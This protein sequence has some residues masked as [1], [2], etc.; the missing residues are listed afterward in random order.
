MDWCLCT[1]GQ[2]NDTITEWVQHHG[3]Q[4]APSGP[5]TNI[6]IPEGYPLEDCFETTEPFAFVDGFSPNLNKHLHLGHASNFVLAKA[7]QKLGIGQQFIANLG[8]T[9][10]GEVDKKTALQT[11]LNH[12][13]TFNYQID[14]IFYASELHI[15]DSSLLKDGT[16]DYKG[17]KVFEIEGNNVVGLK[18]TGETTY[19]YQDVALAETL[20]APTLY[21]TGFEQAQHFKLLHTLF[22]TVHHLPLG[23]VMLNGKKMSSRE[24]NVLFFDE[25]LDLLKEKLGDNLPLVWNVLAGYILK[26]A[27][28]TIK[29]I[30]LDQIDNVKQSSGLYLSYTL[31]KLK[32]AGLTIDS[33]DS[34]NSTELQFKALKAKETLQPNV[35]FEGLVGLAKKISQLYVQ[36]TIKD[37]S[38][39][40]AKFAPLAADL[41]LGMK[42]L[43][44]FEVNEV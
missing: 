1:F 30:D 42:Q 22:P 36:L 39:N 32:S 37:N 7:L 3:F 31:A 9:L 21:L 35:L 41:A 17:T 33:I 44:L 28:G 40:Q 13:N 11:Y 24:G 34:F 38:K 14:A 2:P 25:L 20:T 27:P 16:G 8:D 10:D 18:S 15:E 26:S 23:L 19:F 29:N 6:I 4:T 43:G 5:F 12:C